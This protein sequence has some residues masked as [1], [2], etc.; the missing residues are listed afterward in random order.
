MVTPQQKYNEKMSKQ[1][2]PKQKAYAERQAAKGFKRVTVSAISEE[3]I[4]AIK[5]FARSLKGEG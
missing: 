1:G 5:D 2:Y 4:Q 3:D